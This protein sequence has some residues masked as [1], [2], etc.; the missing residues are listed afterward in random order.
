MIIK[1]RATVYKLMQANAVQLS[2]YL[3][4]YIDKEERSLTYSKEH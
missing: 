4:K 3:S 2:A 1:M